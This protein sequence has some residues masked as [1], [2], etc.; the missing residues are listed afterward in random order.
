MLA[1]VRVELSLMMPALPFTQHVTSPL[2]SSGLELSFSGAL[3]PA[4]SEPI[5]NSPGFGVLCCEWISAAHAQAYEKG[6][7]HPGS[8]PPTL[9]AARKADTIPS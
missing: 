6:R 2:P 3:H 1:A 8:P 7:Y 5:E 4:V 9:Q